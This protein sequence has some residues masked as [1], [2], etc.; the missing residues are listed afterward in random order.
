VRFARRYWIGLLVAA[1]ALSV[2]PAPSAS[3]ADET[4]GRLFDTWIFWVKQGHETAFE[5]AVKAHLAWRKSAGEPFQWNA[6]QPV[7]GDDMT[8]FVFRSGPHHWKDFDENVAWEM[9]AG[10]TQKFQEQVAP[11]VER[12][13]HFIDQLEPNHSSW[14]DSPDYK[15]FGASMF[16]FKEGTRGQQEA[17]LTT[18]LAAAQAQKWSRS[19]AV[20]RAIGG[21][22]GMSIAVP[23]KS[24]ADMAEPDPSFFQTVAKTLGSEGAA[25]A[26]FDSFGHTMK[27]ATYTIYMARPD[28]STPK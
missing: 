28:L 2:L 8:H 24:Y 27:S 22:E 15:Y 16:Q 7:V 4:P 11:H 23:Y 12:Y 5:T 18:I 13:E 26:A 1:L 25:G 19:Y 6:Y 17:A 9:K 3:A 20:F 10:A 21:Q 14:T